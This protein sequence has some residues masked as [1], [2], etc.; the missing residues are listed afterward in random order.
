MR[1][2]FIA[3]I[4]LLSCFLIVSHAQ[5][6]DSIKSQI[7]RLDKQTS[8]LQNEIKNL[9]IELD[10]ANKIIDSSNNIVNYSG[11][12]GIGITVFLVLI[13]FI[14][15]FNFNSSEKEIKELISKA[16]LRL[17]EAENKFNEFINSPG[18]INAL[19]EEMNF[20]TI[21]QQIDNTDDKIF[22]MGLRHAKIVDKD[23][24]IIIANRVKSKIYDPTY[25]RYINEIFEFLKENAEEIKEICIS[26]T[27]AEKGN[28]GTMEYFITNELFSQKPFL[29][30]PLD[31]YTIIRDENKNSII[32]RF[33]KYLNEVDFFNLIESIIV[34]KE[35]IK[36]FNYN[37]D[38][39][40]DIFTKIISKNLVSIGEENLERFI[41]F[42]TSNEEIFINRFNHNSDLNQLDIYLRNNLNNKK[43]FDLLVN[44][45]DLTNQNNWIS[46]FNIYCENL[47]ENDRIRILKK[48]W[49]SMELPTTEFFKNILPLL[50][51]PN[52]GIYL[53]DGVPEFNG[54]VLSV[55]LSN[56]NNEMIEVVSHPVLLLKVIPKSK[57]V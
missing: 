22:I 41:P 35:L 36:S 51:K 38:I 28:L 5:S 4:F 29:I 57:I 15:Y 18:K 46:L 10:V 30:T 55:A 25:W 39:D 33:K 17:N 34:S 14:S 7:N 27:V 3:L 21:E 43:A 40:K 31:F 56:I 45:V 53:Q 24:R 19:F 44:L 6:K 42:L 8:D 47:E 16:D 54:K 50:F 2:F 1:T 9:K 49:E 26:Y 20:E 32:S 23:K 52:F 37:I 48:K 11:Y 13:G 12:I